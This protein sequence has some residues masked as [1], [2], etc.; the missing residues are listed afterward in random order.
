MAAQCDR[1]ERIDAEAVDSE[2]AVV[3]AVALLQREFQ[4][5]YRELDNRHL[6]D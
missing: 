6:G 1:L 2:S 4:A 3:T 5:A